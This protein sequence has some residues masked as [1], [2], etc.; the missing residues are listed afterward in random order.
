[1]ST[2]FMKNLLGLTKNRQECEISIAK[3]KDMVKVNK[4]DMKLLQDMR[5]H[6]IN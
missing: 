3:K 2:N 5:D 6:S 1:M 4:I